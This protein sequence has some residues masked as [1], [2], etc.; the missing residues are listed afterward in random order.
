LLSLLTV[1]HGGRQA[2]RWL[3]ATL[4]VGLGSRSTNPGRE[5]SSLTS[6]IFSSCGTAWLAD[7]PRGGG[8]LGA[9]RMHQRGTGRDAR[10]ANVLDGKQARR[11]PSRRVR[12]SPPASRL[13]SEAPRAPGAM[14][15]AGGLASASHCRSARWPSASATNRNRRSAKFK[16][17]TGITP[18]AFRR[19]KSAAQHCA[20]DDTS[21]SV[22]ASRMNYEIAG[23]TCPDI[24][25]CRFL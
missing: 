4:S 18:G 25:E 8:W 1:I 19:Q 17:A 16:R 9:L 24:A 13:W 15:D 2:A 14:A 6:L 11:R 5:P 23:I 20:I 7:Q 12:P 22:V 10:S 21:R 3:D